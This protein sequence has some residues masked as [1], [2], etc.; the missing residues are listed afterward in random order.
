MSNLVL[1]VMGA[2]FVAGLI[3]AANAGRRSWTERRSSRFSAHDIR[4]AFPIED[5]APGP[6]LEPQAPW[7]P[8]P[9]P[10]TASAPPEPPPPPFET[11]PPPISVS[12]KAVEGLPERP[13]EP[14]KPRP[15]DARRPE[16]LDGILAAAPAPG[17]LPVASDFELVEGKTIVFHRPSPGTVRLLPGRLEVEEGEDSPAEIRFVDVPGTAPEITF[18][19]RLGQPFRHVQLRSLT[20]SREHAR[21]AREG[22]DWVIANLSRTNPIVVNG[23]ALDSSDQH[24]VLTDG[25]RIE[26]GEVVFRYRGA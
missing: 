25:D 22:A 16:S 9:N 13:V 8:E 7:R 19:R 6:V 15:L 4:L 3:G 5:S 14:V 10:I 24:R 20:V 26:M 12:A 17:G 2:L 23:V 1:V 18:G 21:M 11:K